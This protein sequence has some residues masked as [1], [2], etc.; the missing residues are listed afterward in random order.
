MNDEAI[1]YFDG[2][3]DAIEYPKETEYRRLRIVV[4]NILPEKEISKLV[5]YAAKHETVFITVKHC[6]H[7]TYDLDF[8]HSFDFLTGFNLT[9]HSFS[10]F[11]QL[12]SIPLNIEHLRLGAT[13]SRKLSLSLIKKYPKLKSLS[14]EGHKKDID[15]ISELTGLEKLELRSITMPNLQFIGDQR[16][17]RSLRIALGGTKNLGLLPHYKNLRHLDLWA[18]NKIVDIDSIADSKNLST[19]RLD[20]LSSVENVKSL[21]NLSKLNFACLCRMKRIKSLQWLADAPNLQELSITQT[22]HLDAGAFLPLKKIKAL[23]AADIYIGR[24]HSF[25]VRDMLGL[26]E[27]VDKTK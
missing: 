12:D 9:A 5:S 10:D 14:I 16:K 19:I 2:H 24:K 1:I 8:L 22:T 11:V 15:V 27:I 23:R 13:N 7:D 17:M 18:I 3:S 26:P 25:E 4:G 6:I 20:Q 21:R